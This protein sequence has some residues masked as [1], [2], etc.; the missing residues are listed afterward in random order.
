MKP[1]TETDRERQVDAVVSLRAKFYK[2]CTVTRNFT[3]EKKAHT[4]WKHS[5]TANPKHTWL[6]IEK[7]ILNNQA[8]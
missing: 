3:D 2:D 4:V 8:N 7:N 6:W 1:R 5:F